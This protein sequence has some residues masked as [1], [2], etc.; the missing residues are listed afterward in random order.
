MGWLGFNRGPKVQR[1][2]APAALEHVQAGAQFI[3]VRNRREYKEGHAAG[4]RN[5]A[6]N[7]LPNVLHTLDASKPVVCI[8]LSG[9]RSG[10]AAQLLIKNGF[11]TVYNVGG[12]S[13]AWKGHGLPWEG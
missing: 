11:E 5:V 7:T 6:L 1:I 9:V 12:G 13:A 8:C 3:D 2:N 10:K 4:A